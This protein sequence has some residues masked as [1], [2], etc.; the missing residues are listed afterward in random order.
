MI[1]AAIALVI[2]AIN[3]LMF[4]LYNG[5]ALLFPSWVR[6]GTEQRGFETMG[7]SLLTMLATSLAAAVALVFPIGIAVLTFWL[8]STVLG[9]GRILVAAL[10]GASLLFAELWPVIFWLGSVFDKTEVT[11]VST[12]Q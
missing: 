1:L 7:Q 9:P 10:L 2:P 12:A 8:G 6:L 4:T 5:A 3:A 11:D